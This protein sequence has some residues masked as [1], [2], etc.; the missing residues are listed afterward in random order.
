M[1]V[2]N[3]SYESIIN[4]EDCSLDVTFDNKMFQELVAWLA[5]VT[6]AKGVKE[7][8]RNKYNEY[9]VYDYEPFAN[10]G[11][12][13]VAR[14]FYNKQTDIEYADFILSKEI[15]KRS[16]LEKLLIQAGKGE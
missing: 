6:N 10:D 4:L 7:E 14:L 11:F 15:E 1:Y 9:V 8:W 12:N 2:D 3:Y 16:G 13:Y 5:D